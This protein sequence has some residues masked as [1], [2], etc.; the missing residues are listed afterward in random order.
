MLQPDH[1]LVLV[2]NYLLRVRHMVP[3]GYRRQEVKLTHLHVAQP[4]GSV[5]HKK[6][7]YEVSEETKEKSVSLQLHNIVV[8]YCL[9]GTQPLMSFQ[10]CQNDKYLLINR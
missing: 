5:N 1:G 4:S 7:L 10:H 8:Q 3:R 2:I 9:C 6:L